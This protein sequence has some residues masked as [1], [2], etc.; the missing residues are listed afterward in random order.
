MKSILRALLVGCLVLEP[1]IRPSLSP[2]VVRGLPQGSLFN[3][4][5]LMLRSAFIDSPVL[6][7]S[8]RVSVV[9]LLDVFVDGLRVRPAAK[10]QPAAGGAKATQRPAGR[11]S[12]R[13]VSRR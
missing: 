11:A 4:Q 5:T 10:R 6:N 2:T 3:R 7:G 9:R 1:G 12:R 8:S 13:I